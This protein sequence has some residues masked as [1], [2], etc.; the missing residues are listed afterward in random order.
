MLHPDLLLRLAE[1]ERQDRLREAEAWRLAR[2]I[3][4]PRASWVSRLLRRLVSTARQRLSR[5][6]RPQPVKPDL[7]NLPGYITE[8]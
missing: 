8:L 2:A 1:Y 7:T 3:R 6:A 4:P 5:Q